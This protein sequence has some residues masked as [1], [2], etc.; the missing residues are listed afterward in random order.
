MISLY[1]AH[2]V[3]GYFPIAGFKERKNG[4]TTELELCCELPYTW[5]TQI[6]K[7]KNPPPQVFTSFVLVS[8]ESCICNLF[9]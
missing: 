5:K 8:K 1:I 6:K 9:L 3:I 7:Q 2:N 4:A